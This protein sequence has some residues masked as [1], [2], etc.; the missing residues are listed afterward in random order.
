MDG[1]NEI[2][3]W[4]DG[5]EMGP[6][7][8]TALSGSIRLGNI[9]PKTPA[10]TRSDPTWRSAAEILKSFHDTQSPCSTAA[11]ITQVKRSPRKEAVST[12]NVASDHEALLK[13]GLVTTAIAGVLLITIFA[14][15]TGSTPP[16]SRDAGREV[17]PDSTV[18]NNAVT[19]SKPTPA[20]NGRWA[21]TIEEAEKCV[22]MAL[23]AEGSGTAF[24][25]MDDGKY[26][27]YTNVH[28]AS[29]KTLE[30]SN[31]RGNM[32]AVD[33][34]GQVVGVSSR[35]G[36]EPGIDIV[37]FPL[38]EEPE[39]SLRF[40]N[41]D[42][43]EKKP[44]VWTLGDS[45]GERILKTLQG[46][47][48]GVG[49]AKIEVDCEFIQGNSGGPIVTSSGEVV[50]IASYMTTNQSIWARGTEQ[51]IRRIA[52]I[53]G[54]EHAWISI[55]ADE[56]AEEKS[57]V[58]GCWTTTQLLWVISELET[59]GDGFHLPDDL[60]EMAHT[61]LATTAGHPLRSG[62]DEI[63]KNLES[64]KGAGDVA[65]QQTHREFVRFFDSCGAFQKSQ[66]EKAEKGVRSTFWRN[67]LDG[68][69]GVHREILQMFRDRVK[70]YSETGQLGESLEDK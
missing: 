40:A 62:V 17:V 63:R 70:K 5:R 35:Q 55:T 69:M 33:G 44:V 53:P 31:F 68:K 49:P 10:W 13:I 29:S 37:R 26:Y 34:L 41:R 61:L 48:K 9:S 47:I 60:P 6:F 24:I 1:R 64:S 58:E 56:L 50:G 51:E 12:D 25:A 28:V 42:M 46:R 11:L 67:E 39:F 54:R 23:S 7:S 66:L 30:F 8:P 36:A 2:F 16:K 18:G 21:V 27:V 15:S 3:I 52:W 4:R 43:I 57:L 59:A 32:V 14:G 19:P 45:G 38:L 65:E 20:I 22:L